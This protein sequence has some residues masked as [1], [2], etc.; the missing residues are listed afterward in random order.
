VHSFDYADGVPTGWLI[1]STDGNFYGTNGAGGAY[2]YGTVFS[3]SVGLSSFPRVT[4]S[5]P[6]LGFGN[7]AIDT[8][9]VAKTVTVANTGSVTL[10]ISSIMASGSFAISAN[11]CGAT[12]A[13]GKKCEVSATFTPTVLGKLTG[14]LKLTDNAPNGSQTVVLSGTGIAQGR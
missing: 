12:L 11:T 2:G 8:T 4:F 13:V 9:S 6:S 3:L 7:Q 10:D 14:A 1:Q 5:T